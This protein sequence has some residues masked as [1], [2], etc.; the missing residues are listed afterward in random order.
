LSNRDERKFSEIIKK[1]LESF[2]EELRQRIQDFFDEHYTL[3][4]K[5]QKNYTQKNLKD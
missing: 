5:K 4:S 3:G 2:D 1:K